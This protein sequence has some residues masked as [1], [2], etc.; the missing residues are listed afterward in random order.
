MPSGIAFSTYA[1]VTIMSTSSSTERVIIGAE[2]LTIT[3][4]PVTLVFKDKGLHD[5]LEYPD[6][7]MIDLEMCIYHLKRLQNFHPESTKHILN[8]LGMKADEHITPEWCR[9]M[10][11]AVQ[12]VAGRI[13]LSYALAT[14]YPGL[15]IGWKYPENYL[16]PAHCC[17]LA[18]TIVALQKY[19]EDN[20]PTTQRST[21]A[22]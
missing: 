13:D 16:H 22:E 18:D 5:K 19:M 15:P 1:G 17:E 3:T 10:D 8:I 4:A 20:K 21:V 14:N 11:M 6:R 2:V 9:E 7:F 12:H